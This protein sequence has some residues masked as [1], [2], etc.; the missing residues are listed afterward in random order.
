MMTP[1]ICTANP[2]NNIALVEIDQDKLVELVVEEL[3]YR[4]LADA[5]SEGYDELVK[6]IANAIGVEEIAN[7]IGA[8]DV[9]EYIDLEELVRHLP[10]SELQNQVEKLTSEVEE[11]KANLNAATEA[12]ESLM[13]LVAFFDKLKLMRK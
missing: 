8:E 3:D 11:L 1:T 2:R 7:H 12:L 6:E 13:P 5:V 10:Q 9:A 4:A